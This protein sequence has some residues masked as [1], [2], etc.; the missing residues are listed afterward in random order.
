[1]ANLRR[2]VA[3]GN[4]P[5]TRALKRA[6]KAVRQFHLPVPKPLRAPVRGLFGLGRAAYYNLYRVLVCEPL[7]KAHCTEFGRNVTTGVFVHFITGTGDLV[8]GDDTIIDGKSTFGFGARFAERPRLE[9]GSR[10]Y[11]GHACS[12]TVSSRVTVGSDCFIASGCFFLDSPGHPLDPEK[13]LL[14]LPPDPEQVKPVTIGD[15][16]WIG[17]QAMVMP[18]VT[19]GSGSVVAARAVVTKDVPPNS[20]VGGMPARVLRSLDPVSESPREVAAAL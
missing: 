14:H 4:T 13:R 8:V 7:F 17:T 9:I 12:F 3:L 1:M 18:G 10:T 19:I 20:L 11:V 15:N 16:V 5:A 6:Y 2:A